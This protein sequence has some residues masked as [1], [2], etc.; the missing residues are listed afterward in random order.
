MNS[1]NYY[2]KE[3]V[4]LLFGYS[5]NI[6]QTF[7]SKVNTTKIGNRYLFER[8]S[9]NELLESKYPSGDRSIFLE[10]ASRHINDYNIDLSQWETIS[11]VVQRL[12]L[13]RERIYQISSVRN[14]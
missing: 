8:K 3:D 7:L 2:T 1:N 10:I 5:G 9:V 6:T 13:T 11:F 4:K 14:G 12:G